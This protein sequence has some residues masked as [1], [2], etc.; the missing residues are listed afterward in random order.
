MEIAGL[1]ACPANAATDVRDYVTSRQ[2]TG[3][4]A[5]HVGGH[6]AV[7]DFADAVLKARGLYGRD[8]FLLRPPE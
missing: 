4:V 2:Q 6:G 5:T 1:C 7:R 8:V 3:F